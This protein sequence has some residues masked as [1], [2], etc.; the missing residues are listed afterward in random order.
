MRRARD[1]ESELGGDGQPW[2]DV[3]AEPGSSPG[4][5]LQREPRTLVAVVGHTFFF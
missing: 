1:P 5:E 4:S 3:P 2:D